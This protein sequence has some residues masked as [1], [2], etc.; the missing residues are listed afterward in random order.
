MR[1]KLMK[2]GLLV[3]LIAVPLNLCGQQV[4]RVDV[5]GEAAAV[6]RPRLGVGVMPMHPVL[7]SQLADVVGEGRGVVIAH[8]EPG[9]PAEQAG[10]QVHDL[11]V[12]YDNQDIYSTEQLVKL[13]RNDQ[14]GRE[15]ELTFV[16]GGRMQESVVTLGSA[17]QMPL[18]SPERPRLLRL[19]MD[20]PLAVMPEWF[21]RDRLLEI[22]PEAGNWEQF[23][24][25]NIAR[26]ADGNYSARIVWRDDGKKLERT[27][28]GTREEIVAAIK[29]D[30]ELP[31]TARDH[32][33]R[34]LDM[35]IRV[36]EWF[37]GSRLRLPEGLRERFDWP[38]LD[39]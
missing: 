32:L 4:P 21:S 39:F 22:Q 35:Q 7:A 5:Q 30:E 12:T 19:P 6:E 9:S 27:Y 14:P 29:A 33:M 8:V 2:T 31:Q 37:D 15:V 25:L 10:L 24:S 28:E 26:D 3:C 38:D 23:E 34:G 36:R 18:T 20:E 11:L 16:R 1:R 17:P 13:I